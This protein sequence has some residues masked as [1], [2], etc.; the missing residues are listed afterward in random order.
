V[1][2]YHDAYQARLVECLSDDYPALKYA[3]GESA[4]DALCRAYIA[5]HPSRSPNLNSF[6]RHL[7]AFCRAQSDA[8]ADF[9]AD[10]AALEWAMV[11]V[12]HAAPAKSLS[13]ATLAAIAPRD[14]PRACFAPSD[15]VRVFEFRYPVNAY[16]QAYNTDGEPSVPEPA[17]A[18]TA[19][20]RDGPT[21]WR[22]EMS[23]AMHA[24]LVTLFA[25]VPLGDAIESLA[26]A[27]RLGEREAPLVMQWFRD[28]VRYGFFSQISIAPDANR[29]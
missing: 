23:A 19:V 13:E 7:S 12:V 5:Q 28:W 21:V 26:S 24:L 17:W 29:P 14:W 3:L 9:H 22:M 20:F 18:A 11:E 27:G 25:G 2:I 10:L 1:A 16:F 6:G 15:I 8:R 4:F